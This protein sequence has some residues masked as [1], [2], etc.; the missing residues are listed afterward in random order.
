MNIFTR[1]AGLCKNPFQLIGN[2]LYCRAVS[3]HL[4]QLTTH[5]L[6]KYNLTNQGQTNA[7]FGPI[8]EL[9]LMIDNLSI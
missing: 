4:Q 8:F 1:L 9:E 6:D 3:V 2:L 7:N 5:R